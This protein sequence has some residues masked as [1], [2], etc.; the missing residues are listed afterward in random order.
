MFPHS[1]PAVDVA[2]LS[3]QREATLTA[4]SQAGWIDPDTIPAAACDPCQPQL[5]SMEVNK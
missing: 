1:E 4:G 3:I 2:D 5:V